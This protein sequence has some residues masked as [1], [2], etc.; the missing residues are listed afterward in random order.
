MFFTRSAYWSS[1][2]P[3]IYVGHSDLHWIFMLDLMYAIFF[4]WS[5]ISTLDLP[6]GPQIC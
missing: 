1:D 5:L 4:Y 3:D 2:L 6:I